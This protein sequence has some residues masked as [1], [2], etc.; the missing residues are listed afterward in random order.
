MSVSNIKIGRGDSRGSG[1]FGILLTILFIVL[2]L[3]SVISWSWFWVLWPL[4]IGIVFAVVMTIA[5]LV[6]TLIIAGIALL[7]K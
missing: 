7:I 3:T 2:K 4:W 5:I 6:C 1:G